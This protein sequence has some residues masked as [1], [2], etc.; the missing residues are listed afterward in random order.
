MTKQELVFNV[1]NSTKVEPATVEKVVNWTMATIIGAMS[2]GQSIYLRGFGTFTPKVRKA[3]IGRN[4]SK[5]TQVLIPEHR[6]P[7]FKPCN[8]FKRVV[9]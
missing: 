1:A 5:G 9:R 2:A 6:V 3:K 7:Y 4:I 8:D